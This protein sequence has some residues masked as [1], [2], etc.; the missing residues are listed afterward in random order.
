LLEQALG[1]QSP[2]ARWGSVIQLEPVHGGLPVDP[3]AGFA[4]TL[5]FVLELRGGAGHWLMLESWH[6]Q[7]LGPVRV[8]F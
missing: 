8:D 7:G 4:V 6:L 5:H 2:H 3:V 1:M